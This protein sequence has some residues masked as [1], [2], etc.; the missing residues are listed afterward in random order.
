MHTLFTHAR[1]TRTGCNTCITRNACIHARMQGHMDHIHTPMPAYTQ[2]S[3][4]HMHANI[5]TPHDNTSHTSKH[6]C[7]HACISCIDAETH[8]YTQICIHAH[9][10]LRC[11]HAL[12]TRKHV[13]M[14]AQMLCLHTSIQTCIARIHAANAHIREYTRTR[15]QTH[16]HKYKRACTHANIH[17]DKHALCT[18]HAYT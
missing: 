15:P 12:I 1:I 6:A 2:A 11:T 13:Q 10:Y 5:T 7:K 17:S 16:K 14:R 18:L 9:M 3:H 8:A 4:T